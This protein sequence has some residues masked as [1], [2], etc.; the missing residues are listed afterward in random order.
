MNRDAYDM[1]RMICWTSTVS[2]QVGF[3]H[4]PG[5]TRDAARPRSLSE[6]IEEAD[7]VLEAFEAKFG[8]EV[9]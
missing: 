6:I 3:R 4:H 5:T 9:E 8:Q 2:A 7:R 1:Q